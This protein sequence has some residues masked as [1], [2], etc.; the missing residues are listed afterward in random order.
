MLRDNTYYW[1]VRA[2]DAVGNAGEWNYGTTFTKTFDKVPPVTFPS[3]KGLRLRDHLADH[4]RDLDPETP[5][6]Q[7]EVPILTW[8]PVPGASSYEVDVFPF[9]EGICDWSDGDCDNWRVKTASTSWTMLGSGWRGVKPYPDARQ[10]STDGGRTPIAGKSYCARV[11]ARADRDA[12]LQE[13]YGDYT[14][15]ED[16]TRTSFTWLGPPTGGACSPSCV[17]GNLGADDYLVPVTGFEAKSMPLFTWKPLAGKQSYFVLVC[18]GPV[19]Q[20]HRRLRVHP[21]ACVRAAPWV[22][23]DHVLRRGDALLLGRSPCDA[24]KRRQCRRESL[25]GGP[26]QLLE[27]VGAAEAPGRL[28]TAPS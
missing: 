22:S 19:V 20:Q 15:L 13:V 5:G 7:T 4:G 14:Y 16:E 8:S 27:A 17:P 25:A 21:A 11:R 12:A 3:I 24:R 9:E 23:A 18:E 10:V 1:R 6:H 28:P 26:R 2:L